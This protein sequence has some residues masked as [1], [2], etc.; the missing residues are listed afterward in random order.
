MLN[1]LAERINKINE[2]KG[3]NEIRSFG[4]DIVL[5][6]SELSEAVECLR[7]GIEPNVTYFAE[8]DYDT[9]M[10]PLG[11]PSELADTIIRVLHICAKYKIDIDSIM[12]LKLRYNE[13]RPYRHGG[14]RL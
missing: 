13:T 9:P 6:H 4:E 5:V 7:E 12:E 8:D 1:E 11:I 3:W 2:E 14:K 10:K